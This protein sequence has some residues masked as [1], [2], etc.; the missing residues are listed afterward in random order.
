VMNWINCDDELPPFN[1]RVL[2]WMEGEQFH[3]D[4]NWA[5]SGY[6]FMVRHDG[7]DHV[8]ENG[9]ASGFYDAALIAL[10]A[11]VLR[12]TH[13]CELSMPRKRHD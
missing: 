7:T 8:V 10:G 12:V 4:A 11:D 1:K 13:W 6:A 5:R 2:V 9:W 3:S